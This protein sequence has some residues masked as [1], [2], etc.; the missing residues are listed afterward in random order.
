MHSS[1]RIFYGKWQETCARGYQLHFGGITFDLDQPELRAASTR[2][3]G[4]RCGVHKWR[5][6]EHYR[7]TFQKQHGFPLQP[8]RSAL[9]RKQHFCHLHRSITSNYYNQS[10]LYNADE[11]VSD[12]TDERREGRA[13]SLINSCTVAPASTEHAL[14]HHESECTNGTVRKCT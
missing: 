5:H 12:P 11:H 9:P 3:R 13:H 1:K 2:K 8:E 10:R 4:R 14:T 7:A 6:H